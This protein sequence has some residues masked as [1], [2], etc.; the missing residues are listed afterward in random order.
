MARW[1][2]VA[3][4]LVA[5]ILV[6]FFLFEERFNALADRLLARDVSAW[7]VAPVVAGLLASD[8]FL[9][10]PSSVVAAAAGAAL[11]LWGGTAAI[12]TGMTA[13]CMLGY[14]FGSRTAAAAERFVGAAGMARAHGLWDRFG[15][16]AIVLCRPVPVLAEATV[17]FAGIARRPFGHFISMSAWS[18]LG[19]A[20]GYAAIGAFSMRADSFLLAFA[21]S[22]LVPGLAM[23]ASR[24]WL[25]TP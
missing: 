7:Y 13:A 4:V 16:Y 8:V 6:P 21:G 1:L 15:D 10:I 18:N 3:L 24:R 2:I 25:R 11:G 20:L 23:L 19:V 14:A 9:P 22:L 12:W 5:T 17:I